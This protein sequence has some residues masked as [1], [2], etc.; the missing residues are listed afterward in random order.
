[1]SAN[2]TLNI[3]SS[4]AYSILEQAKKYRAD[5]EKLP[6]DDP[7]RAVYEE[8]IRDMLERSRRFSSIVTSTASST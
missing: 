4:E 1:M 2:Y 8:M 7:R 5:M 6:Q 3:L